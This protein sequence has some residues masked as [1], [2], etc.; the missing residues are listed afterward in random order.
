MTR[1]QAVIEYRKLI[2]VYGTLWTKHIPQPA[3][4]K[5]MAI[6]EVLSPAEQ[7]EA[8]REATR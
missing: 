8:L 6:C 3:W 1:E 7:R 2:S 5:M 4:N